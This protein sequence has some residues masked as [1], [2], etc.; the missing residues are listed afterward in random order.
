MNGLSVVVCAFNEYG[1]LRAAV[2]GIMDA[3]TAAKAWPAEVIVVNDGSTDGTAELADRMMTARPWM[4]VHHHVGNRGLRDAYETGLAAAQY[5][6]CVWLPADLEMTQDSIVRL[7]AAI[8]QADIIT[9]YHANPEA[10]PWFRRFLTWFSTWQLNLITG[11]NLNYYQGTAVLPTELAR[12][13]PKTTPG[14]FFNAEMLSHAAAAGY[15]FHETPLYHQERTYG[16]SKA[17]SWKSIIR[18]QWAVLTFAWRIRVMGE[19]KQI[20]RQEAV[21]A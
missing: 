21:T 18:A 9:P 13:L 10:R 15:T 11:K 16:V 6:H 7:F 17:V 12:A 5:D 4:Q 2:D 20:M 1:N 19:A 14:F 3:L 8:G